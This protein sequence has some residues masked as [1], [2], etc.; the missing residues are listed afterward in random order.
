MRGKGDARAAGAS[1]SETTDTDTATDLERG[2][3]AESLVVSYGSPV[4][5]KPKLPPLE[6]L[7]DS[8][9]GED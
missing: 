9:H 8:Q 6:G 1:V 7:S 4:E 3:L 2:L 5:G